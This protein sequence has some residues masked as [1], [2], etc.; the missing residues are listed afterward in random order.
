MLLL[1]VLLASSFTWANYSLYLL[2]LLV[3]V[4]VP[5]SL[6]RAWPAW[7]GVFLLWTADE[8]PSL[9]LGETVSTVVGLRP[10][11]GW[12]L[13]LACS[14]WLALRGTPSRPRA[15]GRPTAA[16]FGPVHHSETSHSEETAAR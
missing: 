7:A 11:W 8:W 10:L 6:V 5:G 16:T 2:P 3:T 4:L 15:G 1:G 14:A 9:G 13:L 12:L